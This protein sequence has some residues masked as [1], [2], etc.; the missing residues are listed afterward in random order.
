MY[1][2]FHIKMKKGIL[3]KTGQKIST[4]LLIFSP[5]KQKNYT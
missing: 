3:K 5:S 1:I 4:Y 2:I